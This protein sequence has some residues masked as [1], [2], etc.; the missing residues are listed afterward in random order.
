L[1][2]V[3]TGT[4]DIAMLGLC[5]R[6]SILLVV[7][8]ATACGDDGGSGVSTESGSTADDGPSGSTTDPSTS[9]SS[10]TASTSTAAEDATGTSSGGG[11]TGG[12]STGADST[13]SSSST[14]VAA[15]RPLI[16]EALYDAEDTDDLLQWVKLYNPCA[17][18]IDLGQWTIGYGGADYGPPRVKGL[19][20]SVEAGECYVVGGP[21]ADATNGNPTYQYADDFAPGLDLAQKTGGGIALFDLPEAEVDATTVPIDAV[22]YGPDNSNGLI[23]ETGQ[24]VAAPH[25]ANPAPGG[26]IQ[27]TSEAAAWI[28][29]ETPTPDACPPF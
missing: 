1:T 18:A 6:C 17:E 19:T 27:R 28:T 2:V 10:T 12:S 9:S 14:G 15:C 4:Q 23:D 3:R 26:S 5:W 25:V 21:T 8:F 16:V 29:A 11:T 24:P 13:E 22:V 20:G 7:C